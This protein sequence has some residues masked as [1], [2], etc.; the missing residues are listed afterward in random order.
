MFRTRRIDSLRP[1]TSAALVHA[2]QELAFRK[3]RVRDRGGD[4][5]ADPL[6]LGWR[7][8]IDLLWRDEIERLARQ[9]A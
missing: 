1:V 4:V 3:R 5:A 6:V 8:E 9:S 2:Q 7:D